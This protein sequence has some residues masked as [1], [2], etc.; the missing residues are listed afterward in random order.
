MICFQFVLLFVSAG[1]SAVQT[2]GP[3]GPAHPENTAARHRQPAAQVR[4][5]QRLT[6]K[7]SV[8]GRASGSTVKGPN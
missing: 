3:K 7:G 8:V 5:V 4:V 6:G 2:C 1:L